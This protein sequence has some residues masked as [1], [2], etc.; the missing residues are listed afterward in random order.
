MLLTSLLGPNSTSG[1]SI[2]PPFHN[3]QVTGVDL[4]II[5]CKVK[6]KRWGWIWAGGKQGPSAEV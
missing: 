2:A 1:L 3:Q 6:N 5:M 4:D